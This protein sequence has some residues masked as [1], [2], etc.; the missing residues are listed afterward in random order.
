[1]LGHLHPHV[2][3]PNL[4]NLRKAGR[5]LLLAPT[6]FVFFQQVLGNPT[7]PRSPFFRPSSR[8]CSRTSAAR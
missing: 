3:D 6:V 7:Q 5:A 1:M 8:W 4:I 2:R